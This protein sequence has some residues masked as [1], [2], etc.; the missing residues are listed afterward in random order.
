MNPGA[1]TFFAIAT[2]LAVLDWIA[3]ARGATALEH[4]AKPGALLAL[5]LVALLLDPAHGATRT[6]FVVALVA[7]LGGDVLLMVDRFVAGL[8]SFLAG[9]I[10]YVIGL[11]LHG[12]SGAALLAA[13]VPVVS[14]AIV[15]AHRILRAVLAGDDRALVGALVA[16]ITVISAMV[17]SAIASGNPV[18]AVGAVLFM[19][20]DATIAEE[21]FVRSRPWQPVAIMVTYHTA[22]M[23]LVLSLLR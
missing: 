7:S 6:W 13:A 9:H 3:V 1:A 18:A 2:A 19:V 15:L 22:Q 23:G 11:N 17:T 5:I 4:V 16:Y 12:G 8:A 10:A 20:S 14:V 21:R